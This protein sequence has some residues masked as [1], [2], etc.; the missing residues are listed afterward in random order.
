MCQYF[1]FRG[2]FFSKEVPPALW[3][4]PQNSRPQNVWHADRLVIARPQQDDLRLSCPPS[5]MGTVAGLKPQ[6]E[7]PLHI[8]GRL[9]FLLRHHCPIEKS[10][11]RRL[12]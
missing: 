6:T 9:P 7:R 3:L 2:S 12:W 11:E 4:F 5:G 10:G 1:I 8:S